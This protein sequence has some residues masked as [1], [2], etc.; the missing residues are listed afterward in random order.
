[1]ARTASDIV[2]RIDRF[3]EEPEAAEAS[4]VQNRDEEQGAIEQL[5]SGGAGTF[6]NPVPA[7]RWANI[8]TS[9]RLSTANKFLIRPNSETPKHGKPGHSDAVRRSE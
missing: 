6:A 1:M 7:S 9:I 2:E 4:D 3:V 8:F 5:T